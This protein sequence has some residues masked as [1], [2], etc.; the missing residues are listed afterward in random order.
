MGQPSRSGRVRLIWRG[1]LRD[2][3]ICTLGDCKTFG[4]RRTAADIANKECDGQFHRAEP[5][6]AGLPTGDVSGV[7]LINDHFARIS[8]WGRSRTSPVPHPVPHTKA[9]GEPEAAGVRD[10]NG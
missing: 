7:I 1:E 5:L 10:N 3:L 8:R 6:R 2:A 9:G 4:P